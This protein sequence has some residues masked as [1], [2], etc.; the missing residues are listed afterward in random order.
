MARHLLNFSQYLQVGAY[1][2]FSSFLCPL[3]CLCRFILDR[4]LSFLCG[5]GSM[6]FPQNTIYVQLSSAVPKVVSSL[7]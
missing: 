2:K 7:F 3:L 6:P 1:S 5:P 4:K